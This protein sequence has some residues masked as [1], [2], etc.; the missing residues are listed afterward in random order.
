MKTK[1]R[2][3]LQTLIAVVLAIGTIAVVMGATSRGG[4]PRIEDRVIGERVLSRVQI[5]NFNDGVARFDSATGAIHTF[6]GD[7]RNPNVR[8]QWR[9]HVAGVNGRTSGFL[10][11]QQPLGVEARDA[12]FLVDV[13]TGDTWVLRR[14]GTRATWDFVEV[15]NR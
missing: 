11:I 10:Q 3:L 8:G 2:R 1:S 6:S 13:V 5:I 9:L 7:P 15:F 12:A 14:R 4:S